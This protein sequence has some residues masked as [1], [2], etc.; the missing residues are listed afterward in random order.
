MCVRAPAHHWVPVFLVDEVSSE[1]HAGQLGLHF[2]LRPP[3]DVRRE[4]TQA[5]AIGNVTFWP[6][7]GARLRWEEGLPDTRQISVD[8]QSP[9][10]TATWEEVPILLPG[11]RTNT[12]FN[13]LRHYRSSEYLL[14]TCQTLWFS[15]SVLIAA[16]RGRDRDYP[17]ETTA[18]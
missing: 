14:A 15:P 13:G 4:G 6:V 8:D 5:S 1:P 2:N 7:L 12:R 3:L 11:D 17:Q 16:L 18:Q 10:L 9:H